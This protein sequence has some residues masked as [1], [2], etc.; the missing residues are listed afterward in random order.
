MR[1]AVGGLTEALRDRHLEGQRRGEYG[2]PGVLLAQQHVHGTRRPGQAHGQVVTEA[3]ELV[4]PAARA[5]PQGAIGQVG[6]LVAQQLP[7]QF[8]RDLDLGVGHAA[9]R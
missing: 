6:V 8:R 1:K 5:E 3:P 4:V 7:N 9:Q 2:E